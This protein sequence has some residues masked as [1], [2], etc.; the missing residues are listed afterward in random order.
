MPF[1]T[2]Q[3]SAAGTL[4][5]LTA[6]WKPGVIWKPSKE[7]KR[8]TRL[9]YDL[10]FCKVTAGLTKLLKSAPKVFAADHLVRAKVSD[11]T[12]TQ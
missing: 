12:C 2:V 6:T 1:S 3:A 11:C 9:V 10:H 4:R 5:H 8:K 7:E